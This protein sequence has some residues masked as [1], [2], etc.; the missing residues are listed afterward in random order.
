[1][2][3]HGYESAPNLI[4]EFE[5][6]IYEAQPAWFLMENVRDAPL[7]V[8]PGYQV[9]SQ[10]LNNRNH[11]GGV[12]HRIRRVSFGTHDGRQLIVPEVPVPEE[13]APAVCASGG[14]KPGIPT[15]KST[16]LKYMGW[17]TKEAFEQICHLQGLPD[18]FELPNFTIA[19]AIKAVGNG[20]PLPLGRVIASAVR[21]AMSELE[22]SAS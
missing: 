18:D 2:Q 10:L 17:K 11:G 5:R 21:L 4:P 22:E 14:V 15:D 8:I 3:H 13:Y 20:V 16:R 9:H 7:P 1:M 6:C 19:G 12:Q